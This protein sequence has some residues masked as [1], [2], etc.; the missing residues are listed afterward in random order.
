MAKHTAE[1]EMAGMPDTHASSDATSIIHERCAW[2]LRG[3]HKGGK[4][5]HPTRTYDMTVNN[6]RHILG[7]TRGHPGSWNDKTVVLLDTYIKAI[8]RGEILQDNIFTILEKRGCK[9]VEVKYQGV[10]LLVDNGY[11]D[12]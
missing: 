1:F 8:K 6:C 3:I 2:C 12:W 4:S 11:H 9:I 7:T 10:W 5:K